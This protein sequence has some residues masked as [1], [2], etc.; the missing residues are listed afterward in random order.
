MLRE[1]V[2]VTGHVITKPSLTK[3]TNGSRRVEPIIARAN[4]LV[5]RHNVYPAAE[6]N[7][8]RVE[9]VNALLLQ[10]LLRERIIGC[11]R[12]GQ[13]RRNDE[14]QDV[15]TVEQDFVHGSLKVGVGNIGFP[16]FLPNHRS[17]Q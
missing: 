1:L 3:Y 13:D 15:E 4:H 14:R 7:V 8:L 2:T 10:P 17:E 5:K 9:A 11:Q 6:A 16:S 12:G